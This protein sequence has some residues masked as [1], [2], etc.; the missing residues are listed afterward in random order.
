MF[1][2]SNLFCFVGKL[3]CEDNLLKNTQNS[4]LWIKNSF[5]MQ[6]GQCRVIM[7]NLPYCITESMGEGSQNN[8]LP[9][10]CNF[11]VGWKWKWSKHILTWYLWDKLAY[12]SFLR[13][14]QKSVQLLIFRFLINMSLTRF[15]LGY[16]YAYNY[17]WVLYT[18]NLSC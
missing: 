4:T 17:S 14:F 12:C 11:E 5:Q 7:C 2:K 13:L 6:K 18:L 3:H 10:I 15:F 8:P 16:C 9:L 1:C